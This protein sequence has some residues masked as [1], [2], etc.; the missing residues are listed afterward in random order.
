MDLCHQFCGYCILLREFICLLELAASRLFSQ[1]RLPRPG[2]P[3]RRR[4]LFRPWMAFSA[5]TLTAAPRLTQNIAR[6]YAF[7]AG[8]VAEWLKAAVC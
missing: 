3:L 7:R 1:Y 6:G 2:T 4:L 5:T 8:E